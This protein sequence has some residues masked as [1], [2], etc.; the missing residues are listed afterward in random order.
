[1]IL[2]HE[3][4]WTYS[5]YVSNPIWFNQLLFLKLQLEAKHNKA[6]IDKSKRKIKK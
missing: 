6:E 4:H 3:M 2:C 1:M 5:Q